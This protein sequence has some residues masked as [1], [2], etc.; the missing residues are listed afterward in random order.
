MKTGLAFLA[1]ALFVF[2]GVPASANSLNV[3][4]AAA[5][6]GSVGTACGGSPCGL[7]VV[8]T[9]TNSAYVQS[10]HPNQE[11]FVNLA[12]QIDPNDVMLPERGNGTPGRFRVLKAYREQGNNPR[13]HL[14]VTLKRN[15]ANTGY[16][17]AILQRDDT[18][19][20]NFVGEFFL[21][22]NDNLI[23]I[24]WDRANETVTV[25]RNGTQRATASI[26]MD[27]WNIDRVRMGAIDE[28]DAGVS[29]SIYMDEYSSTR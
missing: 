2:V 25:F 8:L 28:I 6:S 1:V 11:P 14:F 26:T 15:I 16:R 17:L 23:E 3:N 21:G 19:L 29:G 27:T 24:T 4:A 22:N 7:E 5:L 18:P 12:F 10:D 9:D 20:F 13:Q